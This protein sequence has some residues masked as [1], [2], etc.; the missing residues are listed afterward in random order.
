MDV[1]M[2]GGLARMH[3][4]DWVRRWG[5]IFGLALLFAQRTEGKFSVQDLCGFESE[6]PMTPWP[7]PLAALGSHK[8]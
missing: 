4:P 3:F 2:A 1:G 6:T 5:K 8:G 7:R